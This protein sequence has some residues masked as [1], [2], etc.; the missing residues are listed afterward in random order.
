MNKFWLRFYLIF[1]PIILIVGATYAQDE[2]NSI[3]FKIQT[4]LKADLDHSFKNQNLKPNGS[5]SD[6]DY[7]SKAE[8][9]WKPLLHLQRIKQLALQDKPALTNDIV[10]ALR[11]WLNVNPTSNN[12]FQ[13]EIASPTAI[14]EILILLKEKNIL[15]VALQDSLINQ[16]KQGNVVKAVGANKLDIAIHMLYRA[17]L[18]KD[19]LL[20]DSAVNQ[21]FLPITLTNREGLQPDFSYRQHGPQLQ[22]A[23]YGQVFL[24]G[25]YKVASWLIG[26][27]YALPTEKMKILDQY[28]VNTYLRTIRG[29]YIDFNTEGRGIARN[30][31]LDKLNITT[32]DS[33]HSLLGFAKLVNPNNVAVL[34]EA[35]KRIQEKVPASYHIKSAHSYFYRSDYTL[36]N[37]PAYSFNVRT[38][39][40]RT[41]RTETGNKENLVGKFLP[42]G[43]TNIQRRGD[44]YFNIMP[45]WE[46]D[47]IPGITARDYPTDQ[48]TTLEWG[49]RGV[50]EFIGGVT[51]GVYGTTVYEQ[52]YNEV[53]AKKAWF[54][55]D[56]EIVCLGTG[57]NSYAKEPI[58]TT[59]NQAW[60]KGTVKAFVNDKLIDA[61]KGLAAKNIQWLWHDSIGYY[62]PN[63]GNINLSNKEQV[64]SWAKINANRSAAQVKGKVFKLWF[65]H[66]L[67]PVNQSYSYIVKPGI[68]VSD[69]GNE[70]I[71]NIK[72]LAN[73]P[74]LQA[75]EHKELN[76][77]QVVFY[78]AGSLNQNGYKL[79]VDKP[80]VLFIKAL[81]TKTP[82]LYI[83]DPTQKLTDININL[84]GVSTAISF[85]QGEHKGATVSFQFN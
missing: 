66:G 19:K 56:K 69:M 27:S 6:I 59:V 20:M 57:I 13:N 36:H 37:R 8:T 82:L 12:W 76:M 43:S 21:A 58:M 60:L 78:E 73:T 7:Q 23:S 54:F 67:D 75:V 44:E 25:E 14:G 45:I 41:V 48:K 22:I 61:S 40:K 2:F 32:K 31:I 10:S 47:K 63:S 81:D 17:C 9:N 33:K 28:L 80:C 1:V 38:V 42:D 4:Y 68:S 29:R 71:A 50:G 35:E 77:V 79:T 84:N 5:W 26:T 53:T 64:G 51:D 65:N 16:M 3:E 85:P 55:F 18:T 70:K 83:S 72:I 52:N 15:P 74:V 34:D 62:F 30:D 39:S 11:Y 46:W 49:E 24:T